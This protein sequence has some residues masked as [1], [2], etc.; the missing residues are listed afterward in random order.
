[1]KRQRMHPVS[2]FENMSNFFWLLVFP[3]VRG[4]FTALRGGFWKW[5]SGAWFDLII[6]G[7]IVF[8][9]VMSWLFTTYQLLPNGIA[10]RRW[11]PFFQEQ[12]LPYDK[13][14]CSS[15]IQPVY[16]RP[17][18]VAQLMLDTD[19]GSRRRHDFSLTLS[20]KRAEE[21]QEHLTN[22]LLDE[23]QTRRAYRSGSFYVALL[24]FMSSNT[25]TGVVFFAALITQSGNLLGREFEE[26][27]I[28]GITDVA[29]QLAVGIPPVATLIGIVLVGGW[30]VSFVLN[31]IRN[32]NFYAARQGAQITVRSGL[33]RRKHSMLSVARI[34][35]L[36]SRQS[37]LTKWFGVHSVFAHCSGY[38]KAK[39]ELAVLIPAVSRGKLRKSSGLIVP[40]FGFSKRR[41]RPERKTLSRFLF[42]PVMIMIGIAAAMYIGWRFLPSFWDTILFLG[43]ML[44]V[45]PLWWLGVKI[46]SYFHT[47]IGYDKETNCYTLSYTYAYGFHSVAVP[48]NKVVRVMVRQSFFQRI[49]HCCDVIL[50][51]YSE[52]GQRHVVPNLPYDAVHDWLGVAPDD[53]F[54]PYFGKVPLLRQL[55]RQPDSIQ[56]END[57]EETKNAQ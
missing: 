33:L 44:E 34:N 57:K 16:Y 2:I 27:V 30:V 5:L 10:F 42:P 9:A 18:G 3:V 19:A 7:V 43:L 55:V 51:S 24:A 17:I 39:N 20:W 22:R 50:N 14:T 26:R 36:E 35:V 54:A 12:F 52:G 31:V 21:I 13:L 23:R 37:L 32:Y 1:M 28:Q 8:L 6:V 49:S 38:G 11:F 53:V 48:R 40:E 4:L 46:T 56:T 29:K 25:M 41:L 47:G 45:V 15:A